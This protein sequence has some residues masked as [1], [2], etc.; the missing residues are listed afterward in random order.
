MIEYSRQNTRAWSLLGIAPSIFVTGVANEMYENPEINL[1]TADT[2]RYCG[3]QKMPK[4]FSDRIYNLGISEQDM[5]GV[6]AGMALEGKKVFITTYAPFICYRAADQVRHLMGNLKLDIK[7]IGTASGYSAAISGPALNALSDIAFMRSIPNMIVLSPAD[8]TEAMKMIE[9]MSDINNPVYMRFCGLTNLPIVYKE[10]FDYEIG[11]ANVLSRG[12][13]TA[14]IATGTN[15]VAEAVKAAK[16]YKE[17]YSM[18]ITV[19][20]MHTIKPI[21]TEILSEISNYRLI[22]SVEEHGIIGG[23]GSA[24]AEY[25][26]GSAA[27]TPVL[28]RLGAPDN[29]QTPGNR[30]FMLEQSGLTAENIEKII[31]EHMEVH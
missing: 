5:L 16:N 24:I 7:A 30:E 18:D 14:I 25:Y 9:A 3:F 10:D 28:I 15:M 6:A 31:R 17:K 26:S 22:V 21:D 8:C 2:G 13:D 11:R 29:I 19:I 20:D 12:R 1:L 23:L 4:E 27:K